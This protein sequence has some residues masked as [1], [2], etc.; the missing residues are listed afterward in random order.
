MAFKMT[1]LYNVLYKLVEKIKELEF[2]IEQL[3]KEKNILS[4]AINF[5]GKTTKKKHF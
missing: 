3:E 2:K 4:K 1:E 5:R